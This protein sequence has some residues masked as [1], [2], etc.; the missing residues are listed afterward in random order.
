MNDMKSY[1]IQCYIVFLNCTLDEDNTKNV[2]E[3]KRYNIC[4]LKCRHVICLV[5]KVIC[6]L[7]NHNHRK[8]N[9]QTLSMFAKKVSNFHVSI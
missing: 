2:M 3:W 6:L 7:V 9:M 1:L 8:V 4:S 5:V